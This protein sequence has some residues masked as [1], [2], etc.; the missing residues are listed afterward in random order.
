MYLALALV[1]FDNS[2]LQCEEG[3]VA[4]AT[5]IDAGVRYFKQLMIQFNGDQ[6]LAL[7]AYNAGSRKVR[8]YNG[9]PPF[10]ATQF[11]I[12]KVFEYYQEFKDEI[13]LDID[14]I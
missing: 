3:V 1:E 2:V 13:P 8:E 9:I 10:E 7:A 14:K 4:S 11:Y 5:N 12:K 6:E